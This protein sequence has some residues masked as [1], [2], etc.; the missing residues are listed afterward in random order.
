MIFG[1]KTKANFSVENEKQ[2]STAPTVDFSKP[3][4]PKQPP[5]QPQQDPQP[6]H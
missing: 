4:Q 3:A 6:G 1:Y 5:P 2:I